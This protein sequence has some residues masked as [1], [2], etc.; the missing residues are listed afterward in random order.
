M[1]SV[2]KLVSQARPNQLQ[3]MILKAIRAGVVWV[4]LARLWL[5]MVVHS[6]YRMIQQ[7]Y[8]AAGSTGGVG[9]ISVCM[10][11]SVS[12]LVYAGKSPRH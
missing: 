6:G 5:N 12:S 2:A 7:V 3:C 1:K 10:Y 9:K 11:D 8:Y 4:W